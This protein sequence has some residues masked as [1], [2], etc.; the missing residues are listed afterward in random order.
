MIM[1]IVCLSFLLQIV[2]DCEYD[3]SG[4]KAAVSDEVTELLDAETT[5]A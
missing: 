3:L 4:E 5:V 1:Y 2:A